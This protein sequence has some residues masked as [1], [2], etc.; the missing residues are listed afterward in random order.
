MGGSYMSGYRNLTQLQFGFSS[1]LMW[2]WYQI[3]FLAVS[4]LQ[5]LRKVATW[6]RKLFAALLA[7]TEQVGL[8]KL[9]LTVLCRAGYFGVWLNGCIECLSHTLST[10]ATTK[11][12]SQFWGV[13]DLKL[14]RHWGLRFESRSGR[15]GLSASVC[16][17]NLRL[18]DNPSGYF[19]EVPGPLLL[20]NSGSAGNRTGTSGSVARSSG[21]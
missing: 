13:H 2:E 1:V 5:V 19:H 12:V 17:D 11:R 18:S 15:G 10:M 21:H 16:I 9:A 3:S 6:G 4:Y 14:L 7:N 8:H 20:G